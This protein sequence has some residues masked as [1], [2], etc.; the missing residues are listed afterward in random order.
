MP[1]PY[2]GSKQRLAKL[3]PAPMHDKIIEPFA[4]A[5]RYSLTYFEHDVT[6]CDK[7]DVI[8]KIWKWLQKCSPGDIK[9]LPNGT[10][11]DTF[12]REDFDCDEAF[13]LFGFFCQTAGASPGQTVTS[14]AIPQIERYKRQIADQ[15]T[16]IRHWKFIE[17]TYYNLPNEEATYFID[18]PYQY[19]GEFYVHSNKKMDYPY[20]AKWCK[21]RK[22]QVIVCENTKA[23]WLPFRPLMPLQGARLKTVEA[24]WSN[25]KTIYQN[26]QLTLF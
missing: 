14:F 13:W 5:A 20:L 6:L 26:E 7:Y 9:K 22:G 17:G 18:P 11:G 25:Y 1:F 21:S 15:I 16:K 3:Y 2:Y 12:K 8:I 23:N 19:G 4:G 10:K 24:I